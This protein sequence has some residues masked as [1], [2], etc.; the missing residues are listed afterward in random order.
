MGAKVNDTWRTSIQVLSQSLKM[1]IVPESLSHALIA[2]S[3]LIV[4]HL[5]DEIDSAFE[6]SY[7]IDR[8]DANMYLKPNCGSRPWQVT[9]YRPISIVQI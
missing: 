8:L 7:K 9:C 2:R 3:Q 5:R 6:F 4:I 1:A